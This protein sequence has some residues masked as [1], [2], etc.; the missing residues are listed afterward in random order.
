MPDSH[1]FT[2]FGFGR[3][4]KAG[5]QVFFQDGQGMVAHDIERLVD[6][7]INIVFICCDYGGLSMHNPFCMNNGTAKALG[8]DLVTE[9][10]PQD[11]DGTGK[12]ADNIQGN[13]C[14]FRAAR[15]RRDDNGPRVQCF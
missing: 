7:G 14:I 5:R 8:N 3:Y 2:V 13:A 1:N 12:M 11:G 10:Y 6:A 4:Q 9:A 15:A